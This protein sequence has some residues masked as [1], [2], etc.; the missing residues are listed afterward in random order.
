MLYCPTRS[1][2]SR[3]SRFPG[4]TRRS[5]SVSAA[6]MINNLRF[7]IR[8]RSEPNLRTRSRRQTRSV[9]VSPN[10]WITPP[11]ITHCVNNAKRYQAR[12][13]STTT[14][15]ASRRA[16]VLRPVSLIRP[17]GRARTAPSA[18]HTLLAMINDVQAIRRTRTTVRLP[19][20]RSSSLP[21]KS[22]RCGV[23]MWV[24]WVST[25]SQFS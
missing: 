14:T 22:S 3:S 10:D 19:S 13:T 1:P 15:R 16:A 21:A 11:S 24:S 6:S 17:G 9:S 23:C 5:L 25:V 2:R 12:V 7:A 18:D 20:S 4:G 8:C